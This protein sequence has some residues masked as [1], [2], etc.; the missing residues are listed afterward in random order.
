VSVVVTTGGVFGADP[1]EHGPD[2]GNGSRRYS[3]DVALVLQIVDHRARDAGRDDQSM[4]RVR[5]QAP[6]SPYRQQPQKRVC[7]RFWRRTT[8]GLGGRQRQPGCFDRHDGSEHLKCP[9][10]VFTS[11]PV[12]QAPQE[13]CV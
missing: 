8:M 7:V 9:P 1:R 6:A 4:G 5:P 13:G 2:L 12:P 10:G 11:M 3:S